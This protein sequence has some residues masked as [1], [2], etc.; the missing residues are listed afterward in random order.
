MHVDDPRRCG[1]QVAE[2]LS[3]DGP[4]IIECVVDPH[5]PPLPAKVKKDQITKLLTA[6]RTGT[7]NRNHIAL[8]MIKD[9]LDESSFD[10]GLGHAVP[11][12]VGRAGAKV[13]G[14]L[15]DPPPTANPSR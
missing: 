15:R 5:E 12:R 8:Q 1:E 6:L 3:W 11:D 9:V 13:A 7:P 4:V 2:A 10:T 14:E